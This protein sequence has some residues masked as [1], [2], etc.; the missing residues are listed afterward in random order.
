MLCRT[1]KIFFQFG[2]DFDGIWLTLGMRPDT[3][4]L[5]LSVQNNKGSLVQDTIHRSYHTLW[6]V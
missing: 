1:N 2:A 4:C 5:E 3:L 6:L